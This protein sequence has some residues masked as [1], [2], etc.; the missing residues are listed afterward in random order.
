MFLYGIQHAAVTLQQDARLFFWTLVK[1]KKVTP[2]RSE[3]QIPHSSGS[4][5]AL[6]WS[7]CE[8]RGLGNFTEGCWCT[9]KQHSAPC[10][11]TLFQLSILANTALASPGDRTGSGHMVFCTSCA[12]LKQSDFQQEERLGSALPSISYH[13]VNLTR[14]SAS[15]IFPWLTPHLAVRCNY[16]M[17][18]QCLW[19][20]W[21]STNRLFRIW[22]EYTHR[23]CA[24]GLPRGPL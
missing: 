16:Y 22:P 17:S 24:W 3:K 5:H 21:G 19:H 8:S 15:P 18:R 11:E 12:Y 23:R 9:Q 1:P 10:G 20:P 6:S 13:T 7:W 2:T 14:H 4:Q